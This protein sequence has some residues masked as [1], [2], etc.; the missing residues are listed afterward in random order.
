MA[1]ALA[2]AVPVQLCGPLIVI[3]PSLVTLPLKASNGALNDS[4][5]PVSVTSVERPISGALQ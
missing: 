5:Q 3:L 4:E 2:L 1:M